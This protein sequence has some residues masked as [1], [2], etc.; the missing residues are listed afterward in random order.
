MPRAASRASR[1]DGARG[2]SWPLT[3]ASTRTRWRAPRSEARYVSLVAS[4]KRAAVVREALQALGVAS[5]DVARLKAPAV[6]TWER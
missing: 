1:S 4:P 3:G 6:S 5:D 2:S